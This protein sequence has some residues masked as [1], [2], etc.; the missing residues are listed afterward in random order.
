MALSE[1]EKQVLEQMEAE[2]RREDP[3]L[4]SEMT[5]SL[6]D[7]E[8]PKGTLSPRRIA[9]G[10]CM[11]AAGLILLV[12]AVSLGYSLWSILLGVAAF[13]L[14][15]GGVLFAL[16]SDAPA[17]ASAGKGGRGSKGGRPGRGSGW[18]QFIADQERRWD[19][20]RRS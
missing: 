9:L 8:A 12:V 10:L 18:S 3:E 14:M 7:D 6:A 2:F 16:R 19:E 15:V 5:K 11:A 13:L 4:V 20:R 1:Y 17:G